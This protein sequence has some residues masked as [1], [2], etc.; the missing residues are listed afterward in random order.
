ML[1]EE[2]MV[3]GYVF[4]ARAATITCPLGL[5][6]SLLWTGSALGGTGTLHCRISDI[7]LPS[8]ICQQCTLPT[9]ERTLPVRGKSWAGR[10][11]VQG[12]L[13]NI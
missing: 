12:F 2:D 11:D 9:K 13:F 6:A 5:A 4:P 1:V 3:V 7:N 8:H 10:A